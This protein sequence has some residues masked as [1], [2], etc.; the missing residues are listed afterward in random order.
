MG[1]AYKVKSIR[2]ALGWKQC[3][4]AEKTGITQATISRI[5]GGQVKDPRLE[6]IIKIA[7][8]FDVSIDLLLGR[9]D[10]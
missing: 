4:L 6:H 3:K 2:E 10:N 8:A 9:Y 5:E 7:E 1:L